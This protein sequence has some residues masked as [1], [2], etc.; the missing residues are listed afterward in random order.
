MI[1][2]LKNFFWLFTHDYF[3][4][5]I[6]NIP[7]HVPSNLFIIDGALA[8]ADFVNDPQEKRI[9]LFSFSNGIIVDRL[10]KQYLL[11]CGN[12]QILKD[13][14][15]AQSARKF[16]HYMKKRINAEE[17]LC[18]YDEFPF[19]FPVSPD[20]IEEILEDNRLPQEQ[21]SA[22][23]KHYKDLLHKPAETRSAAEQKRYILNGDTL[24][25]LAGMTEYCFPPNLFSDCK[26][27]VSR[28]YFHRFLKEILAYINLPAEKQPFQIAMIENR[29]IVDNGGMMVIVKNHLFTFVYPYFAASEKA[30]S[31]LFVNDVLVSD[32]YHYFDALWLR[33]PPEC[34]SANVMKAH[35][36]SAIE[37]LI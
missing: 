10:K 23:L 32:A 1:N 27:V 33:L 28:A 37:S 4:G 26:V 17:D 5:H 11:T 29:H 35:L 24:S 8:M 31:M 7:H 15:L 36:K 18:V 2:N 25:A 12:C 30:E 14:V 6:N 22:C 34:K 20:L 13:P 21:V 9:P 16:H 3:V 19:C